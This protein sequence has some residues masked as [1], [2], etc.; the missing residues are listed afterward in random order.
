[1]FIIST[2]VRHGSHQNGMI[3]KILNTLVTCLAGKVWW[4][5]TDEIVVDLIARGAIDA[6]LIKTNTCRYK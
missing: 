2:S 3:L 1:M 6:R 4:T 5:S